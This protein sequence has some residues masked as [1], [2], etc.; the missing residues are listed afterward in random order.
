MNLKHTC[1]NV[2]NLKK[3]IHS[4]FSLGLESESPVPKSALSEYTVSLSKDNL[5]ALKKYT[6]LSCHIFILVMV[7][8][9][10]LYGFRWVNFVPFLVAALGMLFIRV[11]VKE[12]VSP[13]EIVRQSSIFIACFNTIWY[14]IVIFYD[15]LTQPDKPS[16]VC[17][18]A[19]VLLTCLFNTRPRD[20]LIGT[21]FA[22]VAVMLL[23]MHY[24]T[25]DVYLVDA[26][27]IFLAMAL[28]I[29]IGQR[30]AK[31]NISRKLYTDMYKTATKTSILVAQVDMQR[32][33]YEIL[34]TPDYM[35]N[36]LALHKTNEEMIRTIGE[37][38]VSEEFRGDFLKFMDLSTLSERM[39]G[40]EQESFY[41]IDCRQRWCQLVIVEQKR[42]EHQLTAFVAIVRDVDEEKRRE[43]AYQKQL[44]EAVEQERMASASKTSFLR[45]MSHDIRTPINGIRG[46]LEISEHYADDVAKQAECRRKMWEA[47]EYLLSLVNDVLDMNKLE[48]GTIVL[49]NRPF[50]LYDILSEGNTVAQMQAIE[51]GINYQIN[52]KERIIKHPYLV[53]SPVHLKQILQNLASNAV[54]YNRTDGSVTV[55]C[56]EVAFDGERATFQFICE[57]TGMGMSEEFLKHAFEPFVQEGRAANTT[58]TGTGL[59]LSIVKELVEQMGGQVEVTSKVDV[60]SRFVVTIPFQIDPAPATTQVSEQHRIDTHG[61]KVML[62]EDNELNIEIAKFLLENEGFIVVTATNGQDAVERFAASE[63]GEY[64]MIFMDI[65]MPVMNGLDATRAIRAMN[66]EDAGTVPIIAMSANAFNDDIANSLRAGMDDHLMKPLDLTKLNRAI[67]EALQRKTR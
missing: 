19:F 24:E 29:F 30:N 50:D 47:S 60:G 23:K 43:F 64:D 12:N 61:K 56:R 63:E 51:H 18:L 14:G 11:Q 27:N 59:G 2:T 62:V 54:K 36:V 25:P 37:T 4:W 53:G 9:C 41:F 33:T 17:C 44:H 49:E 34:Q 66:R 45:R 8:R 38:F 21:L 46:M 52:E 1:M 28:G 16:V 67:Q 22:Y 48:S 10:L 57:D 13:R 55:C 5:Q 3:S 40:N 6:V 20:N 65:M 32:E 31:T 7:I 35:E 39:D 26:R 15:A 42:R 58:Y